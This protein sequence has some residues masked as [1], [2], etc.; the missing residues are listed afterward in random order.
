MQHGVYKTKQKEEQCRSLHMGLGN[1]LLSSRPDIARRFSRDVEKYLDTSSGVSQQCLP[2]KCKCSNSTYLVQQLLTASVYYVLHGF[3]DNVRDGFMVPHCNRQAQFLTSLHPPGISAPSIPAA[4]VLKNIHRSP[5]H[6]Y[7]AY[8]HCAWPPVERQGHGNVQ[9]GCGIRWS[10]I[11]KQWTGGI[12]FT[13]KN[14]T[15]RKHVIPID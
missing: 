11:R 7:Q 4:S 10:K 8:F 12:T 9:L 14:F 2:V 1:S 13:Y 3:I 15:F 5:G 6:L